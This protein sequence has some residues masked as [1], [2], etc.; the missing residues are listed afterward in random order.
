LKGAK[1][2]E[3]DEENGVGLNFEVLDRK[4]IALWLKHEQIKSVKK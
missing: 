3:N 4:I 1:D 2:E